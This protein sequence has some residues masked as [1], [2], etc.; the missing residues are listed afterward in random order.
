MRRNA[1]RRRAPC[2]FS[3]NNKIAWLARL[4]L[5]FSRL[6]SPLSRPFSIGV[7]HRGGARA[8][9][10]PTREKFRKSLI[11][12]WRTFPAANPIPRGRGEVFEAVPRP[13]PVSPAN[14]QPLPFA[15]LSIS[16]PSSTHD[17]TRNKRHTRPSCK[18]SRARGELFIN[19]KTAGRPF[20]RSCCGVK[21]IYSH[22]GHPSR[23]FHAR[24]RPKL[25]RAVRRT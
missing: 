2:N 5:S 11:P 21:G 10:A 15:A 9:L 6:S 3:R 22:R 16:R 25:L 4:P 19:V 13:A 12:P 14:L 7:F 20:A 18:R 24:A 23:N 1:A 8:D 17:R